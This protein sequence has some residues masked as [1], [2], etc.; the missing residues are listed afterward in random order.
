M[1]DKKV[2]VDT[3]I[4]IY[5]HDKSAGEKNKKAEKLVRGL[6]SGKLLPSIS[7]QVLQEFYVNLSKKGIKQNLAE[8]TISSYYEWDLVSNDPYLLKEAFGLQKKF[9]LSFWDAN[10]LAAAIK[11]KASELW[12]EDFNTGQAYEGIIAVNPLKE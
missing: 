6:W 8:D 5:A 9:I 1:T 4:L 7:V 11:S 10:I 12:S 2:F 3:N